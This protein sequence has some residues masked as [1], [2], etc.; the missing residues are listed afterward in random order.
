MHGLH[1][2]RLARFSESVY[3]D[4]LPLPLRAALQRLQMLR[5][6]IIVHLAG[7]TWA[8]CCVKKLGIMITAEHI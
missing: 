4:N 7:K 8:S 5:D 6:L 1:G 3:L 2:L